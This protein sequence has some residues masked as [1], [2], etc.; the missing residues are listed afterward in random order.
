M[1]G[2]VFQFTICISNLGNAKLHNHMGALV[3]EQCNHCLVD[4]PEIHSL[5]STWASLEREAGI[6]RA[7]PAPVEED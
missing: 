1:S 3:F 4:G 5:M 2:L 6:H 7:S